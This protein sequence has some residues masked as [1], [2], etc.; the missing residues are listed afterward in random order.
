M[1]TRYIQDPDTLELVPIEEFSRETVSA[2]MVMVDIQP[3]RSMQ[4][5]EMITSRS[6]HRDHL[7]QHGLIEIGNETKYLQKKPKKY[8]APGLK[9]TVA[10]LVNSKI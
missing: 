8:E 3:Y 7:R 5:G 9:E 2:P 4:T 6:R 1:R 10:R